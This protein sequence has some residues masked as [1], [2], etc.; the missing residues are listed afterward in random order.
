MKKFLKVLA[1]VAAVAAVVPYKAKADE[2]G[3]EVEGLLW[4]ANWKLDPDYQSDP[5]INITFGFNNPFEKL[6]N[7]SH[8]FADDLVVDYCCDETL[9]QNGET[10]VYTEEAVAECDCCCEDT[11]DCGCNTGN[12]AGNDAG[13]DAG[14]E[15]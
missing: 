2:N 9:A 13:N 4:K 10:R 6:N 12:N 14:C 3:G 7:E 5:D 15:E 8:L 11:A 1:A